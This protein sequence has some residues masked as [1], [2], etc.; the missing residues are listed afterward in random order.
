M[1]FTVSLLV[2]HHGI[3]RSVKNKPATL[4]GIVISDASIFTVV[5]R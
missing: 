4:T 2:T 1:V 5:D 3:G